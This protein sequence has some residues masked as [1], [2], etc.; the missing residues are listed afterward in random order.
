MKIV[1]INGSGTG[2]SGATGQTLVLT[3]TTIKDTD[4]E[5]E[6]FNATKRM[7]RKILM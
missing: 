1:V 5:A 6:I 2:T 3:H 7:V 4:Q